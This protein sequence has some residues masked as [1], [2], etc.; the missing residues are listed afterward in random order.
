VITFLRELAGICLQYRWPKRR[1][2]STKLHDA[3][4]YKTVIFISTVQREKR[5][6]FCEVTH[7]S[8]YQSDVFPNPT[9]NSSH[10]ALRILRHFNIK[11]LNCSTAFLCYMPTQS[12]HHLHVFSTCPTR[13]TSGHCLIFIQL[14]YSLFSYNIEFCPGPPPQKKILSD[15]FKQTVIYSPW[16]NNEFKFTSDTE[17]RFIIMLLLYNHCRNLN[18][19]CQADMIGLLSVSWPDMTLTVGKPISGRSSCDTR[20]TDSTSRSAHVRLSTVN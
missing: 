9:P 4:T 14:Q 17:S 16:T 19:L 20:V 10:V 3:I 15:S 1:N 2:I 13:R 8:K 18:S 7:C 5:C 6:V 12:S 11:T